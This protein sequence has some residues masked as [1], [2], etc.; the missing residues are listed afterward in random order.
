MSGVEREG[1]LSRRYALRGEIR[2][3]AEGIERL[4]RLAMEGLGHFRAGSLRQVF[5]KA[6]AVDPEAERLMAALAALGAEGSP[7]AG[8]SEIRSCA[9][10]LS[11][12]KLIAGCIEDF[13]EAAAARIKEGLLF[14]DDAYK[15]IEDLHAAVGSVLRGAVQAVGME[16]RGSLGE[17]E[18]KGRAVE[19][20][21]KK[22]SAEHE[23]R[24]MSGACD[25]KSSAIFLDILDALGRIAMHAV[26]LVT[27][28][29]KSQ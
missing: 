10:A 25:I 15:E 23:K 29:P 6:K 20:M 24:L 26:A 9:I 8:G 19:M 18:E 17:V 16:K 3:M 1:F 12:M 13:C 2:G 27:G 5:D 21:T 14:S 28:N 11:E 7:D 22:F 4:F